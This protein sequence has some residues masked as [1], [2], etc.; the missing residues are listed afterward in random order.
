[1]A[2]GKSTLAKK[3]SQKHGVVVFSEDD[4]LAALYPGDVTD[5]AS[6]VKLSDRIKLALESIIVNLLTGGT[7]LILD[8]PANTVT[9]RSWLVGLAK[10]ANSHHVLYFLDVPENTCNPRIMTAV[11]RQR[12]YNNGSTSSNE[13][14]H[15]RPQQIQIFTYGH[16]CVS[17]GSRNPSTVNSNALGSEKFFISRG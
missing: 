10:K 8:F 6:Y 4:L 12:K 13:V 16:H 1:M 3:L 15:G 17:S 9:Q 5:I 2:A 11:G 14:V 7:S